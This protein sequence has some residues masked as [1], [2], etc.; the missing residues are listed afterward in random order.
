M[1]DYRGPEQRTD[2]VMRQYVETI[3]Q[4]LVLGG[5]SANAQMNMTEHGVP[6]HVQGRVLDAYAA[7]H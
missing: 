3:I 6:V 4:Y 5:D 1:M 7:V 2:W